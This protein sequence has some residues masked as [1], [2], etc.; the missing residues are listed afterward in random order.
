MLLICQAAA[1]DKN[2]IF[3]FFEISGMIADFQ[4]DL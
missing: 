1:A 2:A 4:M 3:A